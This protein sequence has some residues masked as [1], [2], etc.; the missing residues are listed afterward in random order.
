MNCMTPRAFG[1]LGPVAPGTGAAFHGLAAPGPFRGAPYAGLA[2]PG[3]F[4]GAA[5]YGGFQEGRPGASI[6]AANLSRVKG[7]VV[8]RLVDQHGIK[9]S[10]DQ[11]I[12]AELTAKRGTT[13]AIQAAIGAGA[14]LATGL[15]LAAAGEPKAAQA[16]GAVGFMGALGYYI[17]Q[18]GLGAKAIKAVGG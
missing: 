13:V 3:P 18:S 5:A 1:A 9:S 15:G 10:A 8:A 16:V 4:R 12:L 11:V 2:A 6:L 7:D 17:W 14:A